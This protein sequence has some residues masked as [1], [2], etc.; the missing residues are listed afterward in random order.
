MKKLFFLTLFSALYFVSNAQFYGRQ[1][2]VGPDT[3]TNQD[4]VYHYIGGTSCATASDLRE[5]GSLEILVRTDSLSGATG[6]T[7]LFQYAYDDDCTFWYDAGTAT[8][9]GAAAQYSRHEDTEFTARKARVRVISPS[10]T[11]ST[12]VQTVYSF[13]KRF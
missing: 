6:A 1:G 10:S 7:L 2:E 9:N 13:K 4:T 11:Q 5:L 8:I 3:L 12:K